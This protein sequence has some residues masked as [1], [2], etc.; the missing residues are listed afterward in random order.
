MRGGGL[1]AG[2][3]CI[4]V[5]AGAC[6]RL[7]RY[8]GAREC[9]CAGVCVWGGGALVCVGV[10]DGSSVSRRGASDLCT[11]VFGR[12]ADGLHGSARLRAEITVA[13]EMGATKTDVER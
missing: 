2:V 6:V 11:W 3:V 1:A 9:A 10:C 13:A 7:L 8:D 4:R 12:V 5:C